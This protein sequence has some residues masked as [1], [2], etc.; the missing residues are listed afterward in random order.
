[1]TLHWPAACSPRR[2]TVAHSVIESGT[3]R[4]RLGFDDVNS[5]AYDGWLM[6]QHYAGSRN[7]MDRTVVGTR[8]GSVCV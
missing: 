8:I 7:P 2:E 3:S 5:L 1:M 4:A 6:M